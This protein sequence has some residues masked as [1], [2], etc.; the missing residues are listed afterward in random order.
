M[1]ETYALATAVVW[2][3][4]VILF[5]KSGESVAPFTLNFCRVSLSSILLVGTLPLFGESLFQPVPWQDVAVLAASG[6][7]A[8]AISDTLFHKCLNMVGAGIVA[9]VE[10]LYSPLVVV[11]AFLLLGERLSVLQYG[12]M[13]LVVFGVFVASRHSPPTGQDGKGVVVGILWGVAAMATLTFGIVIAKPV[14]SDTSIIWATTVRQLASLAA[15]TPIA[16]R[17]KQR[18]R[19][20][21]AL[22]PSRS[23]FF[24]IPGTILGSYLALLLWIGG[25]KYTSAGAAAI[26]NQTSAVYVLLLAVI[27]LK[28]KL[29]F[30]KVVAALLAIGGI[31][32]VTFGG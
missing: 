3:F 16:L 2:A 29:T 15:M 21:E 17:K 5:K 20:L 9:I 7:I 26:L 11:F 14:L 30:R 19:L 18:T 31:L 25:M 28:E 13:V 27:F 12:G 8:I 22:R 32:L 24:L 4:A 23:W 1:G 6:I 10:C